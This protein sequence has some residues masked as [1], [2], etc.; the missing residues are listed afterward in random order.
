MKQKQAN[1]VEAHLARKQA[2]VATQ[3][4]RAIMIFTIFTL[5]FLPLS[6]FASVFGINSREWSGVLTNPTISTILTYMG[7]ISLVLI[8]IALL[9]AFNRPSRKVLRKIWELIGK[10]LAGLLDRLPSRRGHNYLLDRGKYHWDPERNVL[11]ES[12]IVESSR[13]M[14]ET[15]PREKSFVMWKENVF[16]KHTPM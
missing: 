6:F 13:R 1:I 2:E 15:G 16:E 4:S 7:S 3:Q 8:L 12:R 9:V 11:A 5:I 10:P 14:S